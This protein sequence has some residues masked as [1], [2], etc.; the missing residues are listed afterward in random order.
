M[1]QG[2]DGGVACDHI[3][4]SI[5][6]ARFESMHVGQNQLQPTKL[7]H[8]VNAL[9]MAAQRKKLIRLRGHRMEQDNG[10]GAQ[11]K[12]ECYRCS[13]SVRNHCL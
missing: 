1:T 5:Q 11:Q 6:S 8:E 12:S 4:S 10:G 3:H 2:D 7:D 9:K 13:W